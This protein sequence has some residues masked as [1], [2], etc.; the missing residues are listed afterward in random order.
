MERVRQAVELRLLGY[1]YK[2]IGE[3]M[4]CSKKTVYNYLKTAS[5]HPDI[6]Y[7]TETSWLRGHLW[8]EV[9]RLLRSEELTPAQR[10]KV[11]VD[12]LKSLE[13]ISAKIET[14]SSGEEIIMVQ[15]F[16]PSKEEGK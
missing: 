5:D 14:K 16:M 2:E 7:P 10:A 12:L 1:T 11:C 13:P 6:Y 8:K 4:R 3:K 9:N 15:D